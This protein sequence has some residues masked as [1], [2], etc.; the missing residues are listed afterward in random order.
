MFV[1]LSEAK[2]L[3]RY[4]RYI[5]GV[6]IPR[7]A[8]DDK[9]SLTSCNAIAAPNGITRAPSSPPPFGGGVGEADGG[10]FTAE[11][12]KSCK[13]IVTIKPL[14]ALR[15]TSP[16]RGKR[17]GYTR[18][19]FC[20]I[21]GRRHNTCTA[22]AAHNGMTRVMPSPPPFGGGVGEA[23][24]GGFKVRQE[25][26]CKA[27]VTKKPLSALPATSPERGKRRRAIR[28]SSSSVCHSER[29][30]ESLFDSTMRIDDSPTF[31]PSNARGLFISSKTVYPGVLTQNFTCGKGFLGYPNGQLNR[32]FSKSRFSAFFI[33]MIFTLRSCIYRVKRHKL[34]LRK[35]DRRK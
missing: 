29:S 33:K 32:R 31:P 26:S 28:S 8:R 9:T 18:K 15:A 30:E 10:G 19:S 6:E 1:T 24:G 25:K 22:F 16:E 7:Y 4:A 23:D 12:E 27:N 17:R 35:Y 2:S 5:K 3:D 20:Y 11:Q 21:N 14:S 13:S 34:R